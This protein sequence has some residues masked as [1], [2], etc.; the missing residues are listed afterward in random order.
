M[1][2]HVA[3]DTAYNETHDDRVEDVHWREDDGVCTTDLTHLH[4]CR[5]HPS[6]E[7]V[8]CNRCH[9]NGTPVAAVEGGLNVA[10]FCAVLY[11]DHHSTQNGEDDA[12]S[13]N[14]QRQQNG[15]LTAEV[16]VQTTG[17]SD[18]RV[19]KYHGSKYGGYI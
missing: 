17:A 7:R 10:F 19:A 4:C 2:C 12:Q 9:Q 14:D 15:G 5:Q 11:A 13:G 16:V 18:D 3:D 6:D 1:L 8:R